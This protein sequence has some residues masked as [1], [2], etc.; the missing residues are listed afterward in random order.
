MIVRKESGWIGINSAFE[1]NCDQVSLIRKIY[2]KSSWN[3]LQ[4]AAFFP[5]K[6]PT[7]RIP[8]FMKMILQWQHCCSLAKSSRTP[9]RP[10]TQRI[11]RFRFGFYLNQSW[12]RFDS[13]LKRRAQ[14]SDFGTRMVRSSLIQLSRLEIQAKTFTKRPILLEPGAKEFHQRLR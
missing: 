12:S 6:E 8:Y 13:R 2:K 10:T 14:R 9:S 11:D 7:A 3:G 5:G 4:A 1:F